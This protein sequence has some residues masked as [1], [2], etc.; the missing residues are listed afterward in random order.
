MGFGKKKATIENK[1]MGRKTGEDLFQKYSS[2]QASSRILMEIKNSHYLVRRY[3]P[4]NLLIF[5]QIE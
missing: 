1:Q 5:V 2:F 4:S 3:E